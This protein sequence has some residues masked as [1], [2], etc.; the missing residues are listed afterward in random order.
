M[1]VFGIWSL[2][3]IKYSHKLY[4]YYKYCLQEC[5]YYTN[6][7]YCLFSIYR[8]SLSICYDFLFLVFFFY[9]TF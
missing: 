4:I 1:C 5:K 8:H 9:K 3:I 6:S 7:I 2:K